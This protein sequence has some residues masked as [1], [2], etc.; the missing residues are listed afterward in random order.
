MAEVSKEAF[1]I[2]RKSL[3]LPDDKQPDT[4]DRHTKKIV[5]GTVTKQKESH[6][7]SIAK[8]FLGGDPKDVVKSVYHDI[9]GPQIKD[10]F[11]DVWTG[12]MSRLLYSDGQTPGTRTR[13]GSRPSYTA[14]DR[15]YN[16]RQRTAEAPSQRTRVPDTSAKPF[17][18]VV[19]E[20]KR[21][22]EEVLSSMNDYIEQ[23]QN[24]RV[25]DLY[26]L[27]GITSTYVDRSW[28]WSDLRGSSVQRVREG[29]L[30][31]LPSP[32]VIR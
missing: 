20:D 10:M 5:H 24:V 22:A 25:S 11:Y 16:N 15:M 17:E 18:N 8:T 4:D 1:D 27:V 19:L 29:W 32:E 26:D 3:G 21:D 23:Y 12:G 13:F 9:L 6:L 31:N 14:Y 28:G 2:S 30:I 7:S